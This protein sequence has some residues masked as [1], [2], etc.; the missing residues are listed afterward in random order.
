[1]PGISDFIKQL[2]SIPKDWP[3]F[4]VT[5]KGLIDL[6]NVLGSSINNNSIREAIKAPLIRNWDAIKKYAK[7]HKDSDLL[8]LNKDTNSLFLLKGDSI[9]KRW[10]VLT[11]SEPW[12]DGYNMDRQYEN[13]YK[14]MTRGTPAGIF[15]LLYQPIS[16]YGKPAFGQD[17]YIVPIYD[18]YNT[19]NTKVAF[20]GLPLYDIIANGLLTGAAI[21]GNSSA[22]RTSDY[23]KDIPFRFKTHGC[24]EGGDCIP[25]E[26]DSIRP[27]HLIVIP[28]NNQNYIY[29]KDGELKTHF[30]PDTLINPIKATTESGK[31]HFLI[32]NKEG[33][34]K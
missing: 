26:L 20:N 30:S 13:P 22:P 3:N 33:K 8:V 6:G 5:P 29:Y 19:Y 23:K 15:E 12:L 27:E 9:T 4:V 14:E 31:S 16:L 1:M 18:K 28:F 2:S 11:G 7:E 32:Y 17:T 10:P 34:L 21:H 24:I 25:L